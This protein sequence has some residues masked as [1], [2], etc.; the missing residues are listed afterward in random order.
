MNMNRRHFVG[1]AIAMSAGASTALL[2]KSSPMPNRLPTPL[3]PQVVPAAP[4]QS[5]MPPLLQKA[6]ASLNSHGAY[7]ARRD[8]IALVDFSLPS[9]EPRFQLVDLES[10]KVERTLLVAH[11]KGSDLSNSGYVQQFSNAPGSDCS[12]QG[13]YCTANRY[14]GKHGASQRLIGLDATNNAALER[15]IVIHAASYVDPD[16]ANARG[17]IGRSWGCFALNDAEVRPTMDWLGEGRMIYAD[18][19][20]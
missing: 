3:L 19:L 4:V 11:G 8:R 6:M 18:K 17:R 13:A 2:A 7:I 9:R 20:V 12:S 1:A 14:Y 15:A 5:A 16:V 10:G